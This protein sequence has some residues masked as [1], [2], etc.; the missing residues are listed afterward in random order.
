MRIF[1]ISDYRCNFLRRN[2]YRL[3]KQKKTRLIWTKV[4]LYLAL[5]FIMPIDCYAQDTTKKQDV[6]I[7][8]YKAY[9]K[10]DISASDYKNDT[11]IQFFNAQWEK[12]DKVNSIFYSIAYPYKGS[13]A[14]EDYNVSE[15]Y[16]ANYIV[17]ADQK[18]TTLNGSFFKFYP[19][20]KVRISGLCLN[21]K[22]EGLWLD[23]SEGGNLIDS[24]YYHNDLP[25]GTHYSFYQSGKVA[26]IAVYDTIGNGIGSVTRYY[27]NGALKQTGF[28]SKSVFRD[29]LWHYYYPDGKISF[30]EKFA[31]GI[32]I[33]TKCF[34]E[35]GT[36][37]D[38]CQAE[39]MPQFPGG[40]KAL[41]KFLHRNIKWPYGLEFTNTNSASVIATFVV[42]TDGSIT[43]IKIKKHVARAFDDEVIRVIKKMPRWIPGKEYNNPVRIYYTLPVSFSQ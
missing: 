42:D 31:E 43:D 28:Y 5:I 27:E 6:V 34:D 14:C 2:Y 12:C 22:R 41:S 38:S 40:N 4:F 25:V 9:V 33:E 24:C 7:D 29:S 35:D 36:A 10:K 18:L 21:N 23:Y 13:W 1:T 37:K 15:Q 8:G 3:M 17:F 20:G 16:L 30:V 11:L 26:K 32:C 39:I 19:N